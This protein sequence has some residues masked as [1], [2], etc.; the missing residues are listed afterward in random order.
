MSLPAGSTIGIIG[1]GQLGRMLAAAAARLGYRTVVLEP[2]PDCP[3][4]QVA[5]RQITA[6]YDDQTAH[7]ELTAAS[8]V[9][10]Y[11]FENVPVAA[12]N[13]LASTAP[14]YPPARALEVAQDRVTEK[15]FLNSI[16]IPTADFRPVGNDSD[17]TAALK[18]FAGNGVLKT[19][20]MGYDGKGQ[21]VFRNME[22]GG[23]AGTF[24][25]MG[26]VP[27]VLEAFVPF[28]R[29]ISVIAAR[30]IDGAVAAY[31]PAENVHRHGILHSSTVPAGISA[32][33]AAAAQAAAKTILSALDYVGVI[34]VEFFVL[35]DGSLLANEIAPRV[36]NSGHWTEA[37]CVV[38]QFD[39]HIRAI[40]GLPLG[41][42]SRH[43]NCM[44]ENLI[45]DDVSRVAELLGEPDL[46]L[47]LYGKAEARPGRKM[48][49]FTRISRRA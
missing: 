45:G 1:G 35:A 44:M 15:T 47:H 36:H 6:A 30:G 34:G 28:E 4:A 23:F 43:S 41:S 29:E 24:E 11:E 26:S 19:R 2:Q 3:A 48:G 14:V 16:G 49:H 39:Q 37:A 42:P 5:N 21:R 46:M 8:A 22:A 20:R 9:V 12:A 7:A 31:D 32:E 13:A 33:T 38:S 25:A 17:L 18:A 10:T 40:A 27:L